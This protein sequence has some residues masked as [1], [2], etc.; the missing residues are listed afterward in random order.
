MPD[1]GIGSA[2]VP[3]AV[4]NWAPEFFIDPAGALH[5]FLA[6]SS[7]ADARQFRIYETH[8]EDAEDPTAWS[9]ATPVTGPGLP[10]DAIDPLVVED[11]GLY[12]LFWKDDSALSLGVSASANLTGPYRLVDGAITAPGA[13]CEGPS[14]IPIAGDVWR[15]ICDQRVDQG[16]RVADGADHFTRWTQLAPLL[17]DTGR[18]WNHGTALRVTDPEAVREV[19]AA[20]IGD[21]RSDARK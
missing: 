18:P 8:P 3:G 11:G 10:G 15:L 17:S 16:L 1:R 9:A 12:Y 7:D 13:N 4:H 14:V 5:V 2:A 19:L 21:E 20:R 6:I